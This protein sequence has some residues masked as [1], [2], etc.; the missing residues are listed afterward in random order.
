MASDIRE[1]AKFS[2]LNSLGMKGFYFYAGLVVMLLAG[3]SCSSS[4]KGGVEETA[5]RTTALPFLQ[6]IQVKPLTADE[7]RKFDMFFLEAV[8]QKEKGEYA[9]AYDLYQH[10]L[11]IQPHA[12]AVRYELSQFYAAAGNDSLTQTNL[13]EA[14]AIEP[15]NYWYLQALGNLYLKEKKTDRAIAVYES[16]ASRYPDREDALLGLLQIYTENSDYQNAINTLTKIE[17]LEGPS[18]Q[19]TMEKVRLYLLMKQNAQAYKEVQD[20]CDKN[21]NDLRYR[22]LLA[23]LYIDNGAPAQGLKLLGEILKA[24]STNTSAHLTLA[25][26]Y[27]KAGNVPQYE[28]EINTVLLNPDLET[29]IRL[30]LMRSL[31][32]KSEQDG[33]KDSTRLLSLFK[34]QLRMKQDNAELPMLAV[35]YMLLKKRP[36]SEVQP[37][38][39]QLLS[40]APDNMPARL[41]L[42]SYYAKPEATDSDYRQVIKICTSAI[43]YAPDELPF[44]YYMA[45]AYSQTGR[46]KEAVSNLET[47]VRHITPKSNPGM[48]SDLYGMLGDL[49]FQEKVRQKAYAAYDSSLVYKDDN[50][51]V[52][53]NYAYYLSLYKEQLDKAEE[54]SYRTVKSEPDNATYLDTYAWILFMK[55]E[56]TQARIYVDQALKHGGDKV[57]GIVEHAGDIYAKSGKM[58]EAVHYWQQ[59]LKLGPDEALRKTKLKTKIRL[60]KYIEG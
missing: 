41:Q 8:R 59:A 58:A 60:K 29:D 46:K 35:Q 40:I 18:E 36:Q 51:M 57:S 22:N 42:L 53:N 54:M 14:V 34:E 56:Y 15:D 24:D 31:V 48:V 47:G 19:M 9:A 49:Y 37:V 25:S 45:I 2:L 5:S 16:I 28:K 21:P 32:A 38:L 12:S 55:G 7:Q 26:Y 23:G 44:Y 17:N 3:L 39:E 11:D 6:T 10:C 50:I 1:P 27:E 4:K 13:E 33:G 43:A 20:L 30:N 52:L